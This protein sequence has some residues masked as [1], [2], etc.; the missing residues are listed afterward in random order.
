MP[1]AERLSWSPVQTPRGEGTEEKGFN[2]FPRSHFD[3]QNPILNPENQIRISLSIPK[4]WRVRTSRH[5][6]M[7]EMAEFRSAESVW[8]QPPRHPPTPTHNQC[9]V[10]KEKVHP[11]QLS[12]IFRRLNSLFSESNPHT[13]FRHILEPA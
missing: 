7:N 11:Y 13:S 4:M 1:S 12:A 8:A 2:N 10:R 9:L 6:Y 5:S 3:F